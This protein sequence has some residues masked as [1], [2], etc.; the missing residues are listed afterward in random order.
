MLNKLL[1]IDN[2]I[3]ID[4]DNTGE[5]LKK[6]MSI[7]KRDDNIVIQFNGDETCELKYRKFSVFI[8]NVGPDARSKIQNL[9]FKIRLINFFEYCKN[10]L[11]IQEKS[12][13]TKIKRLIYKEGSEI[14]GR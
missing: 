9:D 7:E 11:L 12:S 13:V 6:F 5:K 1:G 2:K 8:K 10:S 14:N 3:V 4:D